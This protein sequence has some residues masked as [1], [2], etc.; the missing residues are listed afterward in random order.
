MT[1]KKKTILRDLFTYMPGRYFSQF[2]GFFISLFMK[3]FLGPF[4]AGIWALLRVIV[5]YVRYLELGTPAS[6]FYKLPFFIGQGKKEEADEV[7]NVVFS[8]LM[9]TTFIASLGVASY[10][11]CS[12]KHLSHE[13][14]WG[15]LAV[16][17]ILICERVYN[18]YIL[19]LRTN[20]DYNVLSKS[21]C[22]DAIINLLLV[23]FVVSKFKLYGLF[24]VVIILPILNVLFIRHYVKYNI[25]WVFNWKKAFTYVKFGLPMYL[26]SI[27]SMLLNSVDRIM[28][29]SM[30]GFQQLGFYSIA[31]MAKSYSAQ[32]STNFSHVTS[33]HFIEDFGKGDKKRLP[34]YVIDGSFSVSCFMAIILGVIFIFSLP[35]IRLVLP[36]F[37]PGLTALRIFLLTSFFMSLASFPQDYIVTRDKQIMLLPF[38]SIALAINVVLNYYFI[39]SGFGIS[40]AATSTAISS[41]FYLLSIFGYGMR[42]FAN[43]RGMVRYILKIFFPLIYLVVIILL[44]ERFITYPDVWLNSFIK[45]GL[46]L[47]ASIVVVLSLERETGLV[48]ILT[49][50]IKEKFSRS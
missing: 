29:V 23:L 30:L 21:L 2:I 32:L 19:L 43:A 7:K 9:V 38:M 20:K 28:V 46:F 25:Q 44:L 37:E 22:F 47:I 4:Y 50:L 33:P 12:S 49:G 5:R 14:F 36:A 45:A 13:M 27:L 6:V 18:F 11:L 39:K 15:L 3:R 42:Y 41:G 31:V 40:G 1:E 8:F 10:A 35:I 16:S 48:K 26:S 17:V 24:V 34:S